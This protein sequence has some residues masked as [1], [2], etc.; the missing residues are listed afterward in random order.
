MASDAGRVKMESSDVE[1]VL[2][3]TQ[4]QTISE[5]YSRCQTVMVVRVNKQ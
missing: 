2:E 4:W 1:L 3:Y 5:L